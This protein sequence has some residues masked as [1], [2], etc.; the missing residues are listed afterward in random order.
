MSPNDLLPTLSSVC[1]QG[2]AGGG[3]H[4][5]DAQDGGRLEAAAARD[6][7]EAGGGE[8]TPRRP[9]GGDPRP[10]GLRDRPAQ[11]P[12]PGDVRRGGEGAQAEGEDF[13]K[14]KEG[15]AA[16]GGNDPRYDPR[17]APLRRLIWLDFP[18]LYINSRAGCHGCET[19]LFVCEACSRFQKTEPANP[20]PVRVE[21][22]SK[23][24][25]FVLIM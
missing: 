1:L 21:E 14:A 11:R 15:A 23:L 17:Y 6:Q 8:G 16:A 10:P 24:F 4:G 20:E 25:R 2:E 7:A 5:H 18:F 22:M 19:T 13:E 3:Q 12:V 9:A